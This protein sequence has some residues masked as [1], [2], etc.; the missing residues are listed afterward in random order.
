M[1]RIAI[2]AAAF[3]AIVATLPFGTV[4]FER[5]P[6][7]SGDRLIWLAPHVLDKL[8]AQRTPG[9][10]YSHVILRL[11]ENETKGEL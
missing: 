10:S 2:T 8:T 5:D 11:V 4:S 7:A 9:E 6:D 1:I 3:E